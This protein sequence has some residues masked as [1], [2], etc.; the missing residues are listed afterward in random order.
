M[1]NKFLLSALLIFSIS[2]KAQ[3][4]AEISSQVLEPESSVRLLGSFDWLMTELNGQGFRNDAT[5]EVGNG[6]ILHI[7]HSLDQKSLRAGF[8]YSQSSVDMDAPSSL[9][10]STIEVARE[11]FLFYMKAK[12]FSESAY[13]DLR[14]GLGYY[15]FKYD[16]DATT[17]NVLVT[18][19]SLQ[20]FLFS[21]DTDYVFN[22]SLI[23]NYG[24]NFYLPFKFNEEKSST[25]EFREYYALELSALIDYSLGQTSD[26]AVSAGV[27]LRRDFAKFEGSGSRGSENAEDVRTS[28]RVPFGIK[29]SF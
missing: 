10:P 6:F 15:I 16:A 25:G 1:K 26:F 7:D 9:S 3:E 20:G 18:D 12:P 22:S 2:A 8:K 21:I 17:P 28:F 23:L 4:P 24:A 29:Y 13:A 14:L 19:Q 5:S 11:D 27:S